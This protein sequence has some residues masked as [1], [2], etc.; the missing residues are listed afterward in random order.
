MRIGSSQIIQIAPR[1]DEY[2]AR[3]NAWRD[4]GDGSAAAGSDAPRPRPVTARPDLSFTA[5]LSD[6]LSARSRMA[7]HTYLSNGPS[8]AERLGVELAGVDIYV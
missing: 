2:A 3:R 4:T 8:M 1:G 7:L 6:A 5:E